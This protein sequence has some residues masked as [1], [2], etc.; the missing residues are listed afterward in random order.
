MSEGI[1]LPLAGI[2][3][4]VKSVLPENFNVNPDVRAMVSRCTA[5]FLLYLVNAADH[6]RRRTKRATITAEDVLVA[7][8][9]INMPQFVEPVQTFLTLLRSSNSEKRA[10]Q[11]AKAAAKEEDEMTEE[12]AAKKAKTEQE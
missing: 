4:L 9:E 2:T 5:M 12:P 11:K 8:D 6:V 7:L 1:S 10:S 3:R